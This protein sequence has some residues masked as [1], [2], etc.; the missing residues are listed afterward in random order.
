M[1]TPSENR[2]TNRIPWRWLALGLVVIGLFSAS[3]VLPVGEWLKHFNEWVAGLGFLGPVVF[4]ALYILATVLMAPGLVLTI[5]AG[6]AF[7]VVTGFLTV[8]VGATIGASLAFLIAR[9]VAREKI[10][11]RLAQNEKFKVIDQAVGKQ[12][13]KIVGLLRLSPLVPFNLSNYLYGLTAVRFWPYVLA[14]WIGMMPG[15]L[16]YV[17]LGAAGRAAVP[18][19]SDGGRQRS[20]LEWALFGVGLLAT[21]LVSV[22]VTRAARRALGNIA[23]G[24]KQK[25]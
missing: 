1:A 2:G 25:P 21:A 12:G 14:S 6:F 3:Y 16:L 8:S 20:S 11:A 5:G 22:I 15:T 19:A 23:A 4:A 13:W 10:A 7:G 9:F 24:N 17:Y 18:G